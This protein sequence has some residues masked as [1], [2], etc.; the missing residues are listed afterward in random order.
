[1]Q[2][3]E[4]QLLAEIDQILERWDLKFRQYESQLTARPQSKDE[5]EHEFLRKEEL[6]T[7]ESE[8]ERLLNEKTSNIN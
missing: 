8:L 2:G 5:M 7:L 4:S 6:N 3:Q 1:M